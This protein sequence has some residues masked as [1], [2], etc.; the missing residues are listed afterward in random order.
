MMNI[1]GKLFDSNQKE[2][3]RFSKIVN[4]INQL[5]EKYQDLTDKE[6]KEKT[7][8]FK[9]LYKNNHSLDELLPEVF[10]AVRESGKRTLGIS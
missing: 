2:L 5:E 9:G 6:L 10:A 7:K 1:F 4:K 3:D 8:E